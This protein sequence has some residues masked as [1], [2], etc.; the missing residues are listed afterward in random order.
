MQRM[1][2]HLQ[3][4]GALYCCPGTIKYIIQPALVMCPQLL[5]SA[6]HGSGVLACAKTLPHRAC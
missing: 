3:G 5:R 4:V 6:L 2:H 1:W